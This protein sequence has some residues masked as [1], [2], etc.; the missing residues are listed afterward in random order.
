MKAVHLPD[1]IRHD[2]TQFN[3]K[4]SPIVA[5]CQQL[6]TYSNPIFDRIGPCSCTYAYTIIKTIM[7]ELFNTDICAILKIA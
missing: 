6:A 2:L 5:D 4:N 7:I 3:K 1:P